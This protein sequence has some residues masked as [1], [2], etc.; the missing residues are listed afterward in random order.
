MNVEELIIFPEKIKK[1]LKSGLNLKNI[2]NIAGNILYIK[3]Q[4]RY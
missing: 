3:K 4:N 1:L 2:V